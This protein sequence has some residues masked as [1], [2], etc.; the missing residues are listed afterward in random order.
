MFF[1]LF[2]RTTLQVFVTYLTGALYVH[3]LWFY[4]Q[5]H[6]SQVYCVWQVVKT[7]TIISNNPVQHETRR[8]SQISAL[9]KIGKSRHSRLQST[10]SCFPKAILREGLSFCTLSAQSKVLSIWYELSPR[11]LQRPMK[12]ARTKTT[13]EFNPLWQCFICVRA[14][15]GKH[16]GTESVYCVHPFLLI[17]ILSFSV[18]LRLPFSIPNF[19]KIHPLEGELFHADG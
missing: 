19:T 14:I 18:L 5:Q 2:N 9:I 1:F 13:Q 6:A 10:S 8:E 12:A 17:K 4:K 7:P 11:E 15:N 16:T 3:P